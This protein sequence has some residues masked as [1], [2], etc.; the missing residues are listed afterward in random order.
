MPPFDGGPVGPVSPP[1]VVGVWG[2]AVAV[3]AVAVA[4]GVPS[5]AVG[6]VL[7]L[8]RSCPP[9]PAAGRASSAARASARIAFRIR[10]MIGAAAMAL[11]GRLGSMGDVVSTIVEGFKQSLLMAYEVWSALVLGFAISAIVQAWVSRAPLD[12]APAGAGPGP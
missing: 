8:A 4:G 7:P 12:A 10:G 6:A 5:V 11:D 1:P 3:G 9:H 2:A